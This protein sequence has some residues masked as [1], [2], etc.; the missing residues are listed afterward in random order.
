MGALRV[1]RAGLLLRAVVQA[2]ELRGL[3]RQALDNGD[4]AWSG[5]EERLQQTYHSSTPLQLTCHVKADTYQGMRRGNAT[6][7]EARPICLRE[8]GPT[9]VDEIKQIVPAC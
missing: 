1:V 6:C 9:L 8:H 3:E 2:D 5:L 4:D 7:I